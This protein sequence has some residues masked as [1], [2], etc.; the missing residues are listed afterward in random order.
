MTETIKL[1]LRVLAVIPGDEQGSSFIFAK[2][3]VESIKAKNIAISTFYL[4]SRTNPLKVLK[5]IFRFKKFIKEFKPD[6]IHS[7][8]GTVTAFIPAFFSNIPLV[9][10]LQGSDINRTPADGF[11]R[12]L[13]GRFLTQLACLKA[14]KIICVSMRLK[15]KLWK[16]KK[17]VTI[18]NGINLDHFELIGKAEARKNLDWNLNDK[19][20]LFNANNPVI[21]RLDL[22]LLA[23][24][25]VKQ[26]IPEARLEIL[27]GGI[28]PQKVPVYLNA[29]D[30]L[31]ICSD[32]EGS[33]LIVKEALACNLPVCGTDVG[34]VKERIENTMPV[35]LVK[36]N[37][38]DIAQGLIFLLT[39]NVRG[40]GRSIL[41]EQELDDKMVADKIIKL[42]K[43]AC[44]WKD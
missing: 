30:C 32:N 29:A 39:K 9:I 38:Q 10:T 26:K 12:D 14:K 19:I 7:H 33:P 40:N 5:E 36:Q 8:Y 15:E 11:L 20:V 31:L 28:D 43:E 17:A 24:E 13:V 23:I 34:D 3:Q 37:E 16:K 6:I 41:I 1:S 35:A 2:R 25:S 44:K 18:A 21:K 4:S 42:Y 22:A 27:R